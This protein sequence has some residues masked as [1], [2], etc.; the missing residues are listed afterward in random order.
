MEKTL[1]TGSGGFIG[2]NI[3]RMLRNQGYFVVG[4]DNTDCGDVDL[5]LK[6]NTTD[7]RL[8]AK[9]RDFEFEYIFHFGTPSSVISYNKEPARC[10]SETTLSQLFM[11]NY[12]EKNHAPRKFIFPSSSTVYGGV[13][14][15]QRED[16]YPV[17]RNLYASA[18]MA[19]EGISSQC[20]YMR[21]NALR[22]YA[23][24]GDGEEKKGEIASPVCQFLKD[25]LVGRSPTIWGDGSQTRDFV[26]IKDVIKVI[27]ILMDSEYCGIINVGTGTGTPFKKVV[28]I[29]NRVNGSSIAP[30]FV[31][32]PGKYLEN[33]ECDTSL[34]EKVCGKLDYDIERGISS[35]HTYLKA[36]QENHSQ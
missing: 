32:K 23:G 13:A 33:L 3:T 16:V 31:P 26:Y 12:V 14:T 28:E 4:V 25:I 1:V 11:C 17:P 36:K 20:A 18:K 22:I 21:W 5:A 9:L 24:Y 6:Y 8:Y 34:S 7:E 15:R 29:I 35:Y 2:A 27:G 19:V 10:Y 30:K